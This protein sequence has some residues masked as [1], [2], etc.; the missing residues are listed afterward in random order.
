MIRR[1][2][3]PGKIYACIS[4][5]VTE[6]LQSVEST[7]ACEGWVGPVAP[8]TCSLQR[9]KLLPLLLQCCTCHPVAAAA[10]RHTTTHCHH[11]IFIDQ[12]KERT[13]TD[14]ARAI[15][16]GARVCIGFKYCACI[17]CIYA[18][19]WYGHVER[20]DRR[21]SVYRHAGNYRLR[22]HRVKG[23]EEWIVCD[24]QL[25]MF[26][27]M[28][29]HVKRWACVYMCMR[30]YVLFVCVYVFKELFVYEFQLLCMCVWSM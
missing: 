6:S 30:V 2:Y 21:V 25:Y 28:Y 26:Q 3:S 16:R 7:W 23:E 15:V 13:K 18:L 10:T 17:N 19:R 22:G 20:K 27:V 9:Y 24:I 14:T 4:R 8:P 29:L 1:V 5:V 11:H 12:M